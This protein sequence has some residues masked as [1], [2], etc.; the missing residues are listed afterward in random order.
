MFKKDLNLNGH[1]YTHQSRFEDHLK[2]FFF[3]L[4]GVDYKS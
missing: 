3:L 4:A 1:V 2:K